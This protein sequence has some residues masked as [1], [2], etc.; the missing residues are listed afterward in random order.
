MQPSPASG[1]TRDVD[2]P[3]PRLQVPAARDHKEFS[4]PFIFQYDLS[5]HVTTLFK[6]NEPLGRKAYC[7]TYLRTQTNVRGNVTPVPKHETVHEFR[8]N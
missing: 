4:A 5:G 7:S 8:Q 2:T 3:R 1:G 6:G